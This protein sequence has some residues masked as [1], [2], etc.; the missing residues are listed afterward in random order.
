[1]RA[2]AYSLC[3]FSDLNLAT[4]LNLLVF[5]FQPV[6]PGLAD[7]GSSFSREAQMLLS[8]ATSPPGALLKAPFELLILAVRLTVRD[9]EPTPLA[10]S[11]SLL[12][13]VGDR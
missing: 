5:N 2:H 6:G 7:G 4:I 12:P 1:M 9:A 3:G 13:S 10:I 11:R 8:P